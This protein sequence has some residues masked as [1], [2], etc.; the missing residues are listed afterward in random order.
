MN[1]GWVVTF[2]TAYA[3]L[4][5]AGMLISFAMSF[6]HCEKVDVSVSA[7]Q[8]AIFATL[9]AGTVI[10]A[11]FVP[12]AIRPFENVLRDV[13]SV[14]PESAPTLGMAYVMMLLAWIMAARM[15]DA[16]QKAVCIPTVDEVALFKQRIQEK[17]AKKD[18]KEEKRT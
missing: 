6:F 4:F 13:F 7:I 8:A 1:T 10:L 15:T 3:V 11:E 9:P 12:A 5:V 2:G 14:S 18:I 16:V 17:Q